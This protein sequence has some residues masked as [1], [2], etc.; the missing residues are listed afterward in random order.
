MDDL[1]V[2]LA[3]VDACAV[4]DALDKLGLTGAVTGMQRLS[5]DRRIPGRVVTVKLD[6]A[7]RPPAGAAAS[8]HG[9][10][11]SSAGRETSSS[12]SSE[13][14]SMRRAGA[15]TS[16]SAPSCGCG[17][18]H[19][20]RP[21][22]RYRRVSHAT[23]S[24]CS[25]ARTPRAPRADASSRPATNVPITVGDI[26]SR[27]A[28]TSSPTAA[29]WCSSAQS[30]SSGARGRRSDRQRERAMAA[31]LREGTPISQVMGKTYETMLKK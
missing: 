9:R 19:R 10:H 15:A 11:R 14:A 13:P 29:P 4:S 26:A 7:R 25:P 17:R 16:R 23:T 31:S 30:T 27:R 6:R 12:S 28:T 3:L 18:R 5:T 20:R 22:A 8:G 24:R 21:G 2:R 1:L